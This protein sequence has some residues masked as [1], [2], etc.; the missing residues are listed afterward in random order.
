MCLFTIPGA[1]QRRTAVA[2]NIDI[3]RESKYFTR[4]DDLVIHGCEQVLRFTQVE[5]WDD[6]SEG[7]KVQ[8]GFNMGVLALG[9]KLTKA[10]GFHA[11][12]DAREGRVSMQAFRNHLKALIDSHKVE[13]DEAKIARPF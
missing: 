5:R 13:V 9:L 8:L 11:L 1:T 12:V 4:M 7:V 3:N 10:E 6:L 2:K